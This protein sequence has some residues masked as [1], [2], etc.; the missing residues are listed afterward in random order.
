MG[1]TFY[2]SLI[3]F[4]LNVKLNIFWSDFCHFGNN[5]VK[6]CLLPFPRVVIFVLFNYYRLKFTQIGI[7]QAETYTSYWSKEFLWF[8]RHIFLD[9][10]KCLVLRNCRLKL[11]HFWNEC[12]IHVG[13]IYNIN[14]YYIQTRES[15]VPF[16]SATRETR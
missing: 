6:V 2:A 16:N 8:K 10:I 15:G 12:K 1:D 4:L 5:R 3:A 13:D 11:V 14:K 9:K 7:L